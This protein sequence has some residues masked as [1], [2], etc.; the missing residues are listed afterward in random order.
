MA[1]ATSIQT[2]STKAIW[3][4]HFGNR[5][6]VPLSETEAFWEELNTACQIEDAQKNAQIGDCHT[7]VMY[8]PEYRHCIQLDIWF[9]DDGAEQE[10]KC[11]YYQPDPSNN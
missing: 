7:C 5:A 11:P 1:Q 3:E 8:E 4:R 9:Q 10:G 6:S 2:T